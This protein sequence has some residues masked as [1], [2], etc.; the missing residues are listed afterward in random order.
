MGYAIGLE[1]EPI[2]RKRCNHQDSAA[3]E[4]EVL[5]ELSTEIQAKDWQT[6]TVMAGM[7]LAPIVPAEDSSTLREFARVD[8]YTQSC[9]A[10]VRT[11]R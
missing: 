1:V 6:H 2:F 9:Q 11:G 10:R 5:I 7:D 8:V 3:V 4:S